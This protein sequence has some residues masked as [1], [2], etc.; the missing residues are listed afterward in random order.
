[1]KIDI[2]AARANPGQYV[3]FEMN[4]A[5][6]KQD[7]NGEKL[8]FSDLNAHGCV[9]AGEDTL[10]IDGE[11][12]ATAHMRCSACLDPAQAMVVAHFDEMFASRAKDDDSDV[13]P[14]PSGYSVEMDDVL[15]GA[16]M[17]ELPMRMLCSSD[18]PGLCPECGTPKSIGCTCEAPTSDNPFSKLKEAFQTD[19]EV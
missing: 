4:G 14:L 12:H 7:V 18:C 5:L 15:L 16:L 1:M 17:L 13:R 2:S 9:V 10:G 11:V 19:E 6:P 8:T 3:P